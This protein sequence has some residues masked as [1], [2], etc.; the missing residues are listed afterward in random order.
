MGHG[1]GSRRTFQ[2]GRASSY[3]VC[4]SVVSVGILRVRAECV[5]R[6]II[7][8]ERV[9]KAHF[10]AVDGA[11]AGALEDG[12]EAMVLGVEDDALG[13]GLGLRYAVRNMLLIV[14]ITSQTG[15]GLQIAP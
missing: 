5:C 12:E 4:V 6:G 13:G 2:T 7:I 8:H 9:R 3:C 11:I 1:V 14:S 10:G 15:L